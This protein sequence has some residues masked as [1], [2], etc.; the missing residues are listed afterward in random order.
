VGAGHHC[1]SASEPFRRTGFIETRIFTI[2]AHVSRIYT[3]AVHPWVVEVALASL[4]EEDLEVVVQV[5]Q[6][7]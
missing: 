4:D 5:G 3:R 7:T 1:L 6:P 2:K